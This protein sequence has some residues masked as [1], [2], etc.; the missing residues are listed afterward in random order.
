MEFWVNVFPQQV[1]N[2]NFVQ[3][4]IRY[5]NSLD[6][7]NG[8]GCSLQFTTNAKQILKSGVPNSGPGAIFRLGT[9]AYLALCL[10]SVI[11]LR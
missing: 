10:M 11:I 3:N 2:F 5:S 6:F 7:Q 8:N 1:T 9:P 4:S